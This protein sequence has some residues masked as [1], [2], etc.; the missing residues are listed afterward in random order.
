VIIHEC[1]Q[2]TPEWS[3]LRAGI[4]TASAFDRIITPGGAASK[5]A[6]KYKFY[7]LA[8]RIQGKPIDGVKTWSME[9]GSTLEVKAKK[10]YQWVTGTS[11]T[12][13]GFIT[14]DEETWGAS[15][16]DF[17]GEDGLLEC[18]CPEL[19]THM[20]YLMREGTAY[21][22]YKVQCQGQL[23]VTGRQF[24][25]VLSY[26][27][28][29]PWALQRIERDEEF[30]GKLAIEIPKFSAELEALCAEAKERGWS[31]V[32]DT[33]KPKPYSQA[34][35]VDAVREALLDTQRTT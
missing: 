15:P 22:E 14:N 25:D 31:L 12:P 30:I 9:R 11:T 18:K 16:D 4:P 32:K 7:L 34:S 3:Y 28:G 23:W 35:V 29:L 13:V 6:E 1:V 27:P 26:Y 33:A 5:S 21:K 19:E 8:E 17:V 20:M 24:V 2:G 10:H